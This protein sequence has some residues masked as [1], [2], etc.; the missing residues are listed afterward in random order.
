MAKRKNKPA[1][2][3]QSAGHPQ[4]KSQGG[5]GQ[6]RTAKGV[7][8]QP[9][10]AAT[11]TRKRLPVVIAVGV[12]IAAAVVGIALQSQRTAKPKPVVTPAHE[13]GPSGS[14][15]RGD[16]NAKVLV[17]VF[18]DFQCP[19]CKDWDLATSATITN[20]VSSGR[21]RFAYY[22]LSFIGP[23]SERAAAASICAADEGAYWKYSELLW[24]RQSEKEN[25]GY[26]SID[27]LIGFGRDLQIA[28]PAFEKCVRDQTYLPWIGK[29]ADEGVKRKVQGTP[30]IFVNGKVLEQHTLEGLLTAVDLASKS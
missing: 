19:A 18:G 12:I 2:K 20:L 13:L 22:P 7:A 25:S 28:T 16:P 30:T 9:A 14:E 27:R 8:S 23:E 11:A 6:A 26:L 1:G 17:E 24:Q 3:G 10:K 15:V 21:V 4:G 5:G 29:I